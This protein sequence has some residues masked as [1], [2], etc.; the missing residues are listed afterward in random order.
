ML[1]NNQM[2]IDDDLGL[3]FH[4]LPNLY[5]VLLKN[6]D[7][8][9]FIQKRT[10]VN[11][12]NAKPKKGQSILLCGLLNAIDGIVFSKDVVLITNHLAKLYDALIHHG[13]VDFNI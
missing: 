11:S 7:A 3:L 10:T 8:T 4:R 12:G 1:L 13:L 9:S 2:L 5:I 6:I